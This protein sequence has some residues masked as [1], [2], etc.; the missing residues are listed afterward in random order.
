M[1][2][3]GISF[4]I[5]VIAGLVSAK[6]NISVGEATEITFRI[7]WGQALMPHIRL[8]LRQLG[9]ALRQ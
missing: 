9:W 5:V 8:G 7:L 2:I 4:D 6:T 1:S 3:V